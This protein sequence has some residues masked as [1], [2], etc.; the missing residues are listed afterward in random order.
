MLEAQ[1]L[2]RLDVGENQ[3]GDERLVATAT[4]GPYD[5]GG[6]EIGL[7]ALAL[8]PIARGRLAAALNGV[9][10]W[11][12][13]DWFVADRIWLAFPLRAASGQ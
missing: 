1:S 9:P 3:L 2:G 6:G 11:H 12:N 5:H 4:I 7:G 8:E 13:V 10:L